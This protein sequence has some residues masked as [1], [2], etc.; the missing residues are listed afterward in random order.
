[1]MKAR[2]QGRD[3]HAQ[4]N[5]TERQKARD[6]AAEQEQ[7]LLGMLLKSPEMLSKAQILDTADL[8]HPEVR[9]ALTWL[10]SLATGNFGECW[11][12]ALADEVAKEHRRSFDQA[13]A[14]LFEL[15]RTCVSAANVANQAVSL[16]LSALGA[17]IVDAMAAGDAERV[18]TLLNE[19]DGIKAR[20]KQPAVSRFTRLSEMEDRLESP[21]WLVHGY[22]ERDTVTQIFGDPGSGKSFVALDIALSVATGQP[23]QGRETS[24][25]PVFYIAGEGLRG[26]QRRKEAWLRH[27]GI[28]DRSAPFWFS[29]Q[30]IAFSDANQLAITINDIDRAIAGGDL[31]ALIVVDTLARNFGNGDENSTKDM[32]AFIAALD[33]IRQRYHCCILLVHH[34]GH[35]DKSRARG[36][37][38]LLGSL[39]AEYQITKAGDGLI[40]MQSTKQKDNDHPVPLSW[41]LSRFDL[42]SNNDEGNPLHSAVLIPSEA[43]FVESCGAKDS[44]LR[45][46]PKRALECLQELY[47]RQRQNLTDSGHDSNTARVNLQDWMDAMLSINPDRG[48]RAR[49]RTTLVDRK[50]VRIEG[51]YVYLL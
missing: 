6:F 5:A 33:I 18:R 42:L 43:G 17:Q 25:G 23:W 27:H 22:F 13:T 28:S 9:T 11:K 26:L 34:S 15:E 39:D 1:M 32:G 7:L 40:V 45:G 51:R 35:A 24:T 49:L 19:Q 21:D 12:T 30:S 50:L 36:A 16:K 41:M 47:E 14:W 46:Q 8:T 3:S 10:R 38:A 44:E 4:K 29:N 2:N 31:P 37:I 48:N 20:S